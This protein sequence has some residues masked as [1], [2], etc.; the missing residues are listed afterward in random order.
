MRSLSDSTHSHKKPLM[1]SWLWFQTERVIYSLGMKSNW[2]R[3]CKQFSKFQSLVIF[4]ESGILFIF[5]H[6]FRFLIST[7]I[8]PQNI[9]VTY[10]QKTTNLTANQSIILSDEPNEVRVTLT[11]GSNATIIVNGV[12]F[13]TTFGFEDEAKFFRYASFSLAPELDFQEFFFECDAPP[14]E[15]DNGP[16][17]PPTTPEQPL[18]T[19]SQPL[20]QN[21]FEL[22]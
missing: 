3:I 11:G 21:V 2:V 10:N 7:V 12:P 17:E 18:N 1:C 15:P 5:R 22:Q 8:A 19:P 13:N 14:T 6:F 9:Y 20:S 16:Q 4:I